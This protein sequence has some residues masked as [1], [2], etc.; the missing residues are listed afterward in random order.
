MPWVHLS[1]KVAVAG[2]EFAH[3]GLKVFVKK[4]VSR[5]APRLFQGTSYL[6]VLHVLDHKQEGQSN[7][8]LEIQTNEVMG[9]Y[10]DN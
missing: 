10:G 2:R 7:L 6:C 1:G 4:N 8:F 3:E 9:S 5:E